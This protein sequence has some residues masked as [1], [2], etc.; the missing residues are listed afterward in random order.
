VESGTS[1]SLAVAGSRVLVIDDDRRALEAV[2]GAFLDCKVTIESRA[3]DAIRRIEG[4]AR[5]DVIF[6][7]LTMREMSG[8]ELYL[9]VARVDTEQAARIVFSTKGGGLS[10]E[11]LAEHRGIEEPFEALELRAVAATVLDGLAR[12]A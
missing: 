7:A 6:C 2:W 9:H 4:G 5:Y 12:S 11:F 1:C 10:D 3:S 8:A